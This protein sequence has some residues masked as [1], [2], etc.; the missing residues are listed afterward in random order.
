MK[1]AEFRPRRGLRSPHVQ[2]VLASGGLRRWLHRDRH[3]ELI[4]HAAPVDVDAGDGVRL[5]GALTRQRQR[6]DA[7]G[8]IVLLHGWEGSIDSTYMLHTGAE[9]LRR[10]FDVFRLNFRDHG[11][12]HGLNRELFHSCRIEEVVR[13]V[14]EVVHQ[15]PAPLH[16][17]AGFSLGGNFTLRVAL[18]SRAAGFDLGHAVAVC[19]V[20]NP[21]HGLDAI[22][23]AP[24]FYERY[25]VRKWRASLK[26]KQALFPDAFDFSRWRADASLRELTRELVAAHTPFPSIDDYLDGY[27][28]A[29]DRLQPL[30]VPT[31]IVTAKDDPII[32][33]ADF[34]AL[35]LSSTT[36]LDIAP[37]GG[38][39]GFIHDW[40][41][42]SVIE[43]YI[44]DRFERAAP[45]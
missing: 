8:L 28:I 35:K 25:F 42:K 6:P 27:S 9:L 36:E 4:H 23:S 7:R 33:V 30:D 2:S 22:E 39:C 21:R 15:H 13:A 40:R 31:T 24:W 12:T 34:L 37:Y 41:L 26:R 19:P 45:V 18:K 17:L 10:G 32:P 5:R 11:D 20:I 43:H 16:G 1:A 3:A 44:A 38:H 14:R 29:G